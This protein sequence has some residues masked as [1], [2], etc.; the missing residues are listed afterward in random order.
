M[1][2]PSPALPPRLMHAVGQ[3][4]ADIRLVGADGLELDAVWN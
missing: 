4:A 2:R 1:Q 3:Y